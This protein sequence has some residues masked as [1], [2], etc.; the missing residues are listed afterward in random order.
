MEIKSESHD[1]PMHLLEVIRVRKKGQMNYTLFEIVFKNGII[2][3]AT[4]YH[5]FT[6]LRDGEKLY[7]PTALLSK[8]DLIWVDVSAFV[9]D[10]SIFVGN[11]HK[12][13]LREALKS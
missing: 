5:A 1:G 3:V 11:K 12:R 7:L 4:Q 8:H 10:G 2:L 13:T 6:C 9:A